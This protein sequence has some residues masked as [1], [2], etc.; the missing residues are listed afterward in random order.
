ML[1]NNIID[2]IIKNALQEDLGWGDVTTD[3]TI[4]DTAVIRGNFIAKEEGIICGI[5]VC[6]RVFEMV[7]RS[8]DFQARMKD[9]QIASK[10]DII[11]EISGNARSILKGERTALNFFQRMSGIATMTSKYVSEISGLKT[12][13]VDTRKTA[14]GLRILD[15]YSVK[16]GGGFNHRFNLSDMVLIKDNHIKAAGGITPAVAAAKGKCSHALKIEVEVESIR[17]LIEAIEAGADIVMLDNMTLDM[18]KEAV[19]IAS[20]KVLL[21]AS[22]NITIGGERS[23]R[24]VAETGVDIISAGALTNSVKAMDIS[25]R[26]L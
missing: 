24:A 9:G 7:D 20:G 1:D 16:V 8:I 25:L 12:R 26:F 5:E 11:A 15:K 4:P 19:S 17:E 2:R 6:R 18:M 3:S 23:V 13:I 22:G 14:P 10:G 21:E